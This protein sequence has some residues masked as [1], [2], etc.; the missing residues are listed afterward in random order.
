MRIST[1]IKILLKEHKNNFQHHIAD[2][3][4]MQPTHP[5]RASTL[6]YLAS[7][8]FVLSGIG[9]GIYEINGSSE[10]II[11]TAVTCTLTALDILIEYSYNTEKIT[12]KQ[13]YYKQINQYGNK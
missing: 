4:I 13:H 1:E 12:R 2:L 3:K 5:T 7:T 9:K 8:L 11:F 10:L 6:F